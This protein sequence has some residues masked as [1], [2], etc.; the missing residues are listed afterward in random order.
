MDS[1]YEQRSRMSIYRGGGCYCTAKPCHCYS[2]YCWIGDTLTLSGSGVCAWENVCVQC[3]AGHRINCVSVRA[4]AHTRAHCTACTVSK[5][6]DKHVGVSMSVLTLC[7]CWYRC[8]LSHLR[9]LWSESVP[10]CFGRRSDP[11]AT[12]TGPPVLVPSHTVPP[13]SP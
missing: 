8:V 7:M 5:C 11:V 6:V 4:C 13:N 10:V 3:V 9:A 1:L 2:C 12:T